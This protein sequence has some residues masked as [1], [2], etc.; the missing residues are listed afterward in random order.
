MVY[1][2]LKEAQVE[3]E[4]VGVGV[5]WGERRGESGKRTNR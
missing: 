2:K 1:L 4:R 3:V 5:T